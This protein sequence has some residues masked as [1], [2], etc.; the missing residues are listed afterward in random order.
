V[1]KSVAVFALAVVVAVLAIGSMRDDSATAD[2][3]AHIAAGLLKVREGRIDLYATQTP[4]IESLIAMPLAIAGE[5]VPDQ[6]RSMGNRPWVFGHLLL[7][8]G[9]SDAQR[10][11]RMARLP[12]IALFLALCFA[13]WGFV[14]EVTGNDAAALAAFAM[15]GFCPTLLAHGRLAT[16][17]MGVTFFAFLATALFLRLL[18]APSKG[19]AIATGVAVACTLASKISGAL[20]LPFFAIVL[21]LWFAERRRPAPADAGGVPRRRLFWLEWRGG[22]ETLPASAGG[23][24]GVPLAAITCIATFI[25]IYLVLGRSFDLMLPFRAYLSELRAVRAFYV[26]NPLPQFLL[27]EFSQKGW[28]QYYLVAMAVKTPLPAL[29]LLV[30]GVL[31]TRRF[32]GI[33]CIVFAALFLL[34]S[35]F[36]SLNLGIRHVLP[37]YPFLY[38]A[39]A[40]AL[41]DASRRMRIAAGVLV[42]AHVLVALLAYPSYLSYFNALIGSPRNADRILIDSNLDWGQDLRRLGLWARA[43]DVDVVRVHYFGAG[44]VELELG[45]RGARWPAPRPQLLPKG[46]FAVSRHFYRLSFLPSRSPIDYDTYLRASHA[47]YVTTI[48]GSIDVYRVD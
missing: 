17:D 16:V 20:L 4:L 34:V 33:V 15:T 14:R 7:Y 46:W 28:P 21:V 38:A 40:I 24:A 43:N 30:I 3:A 44:N 37:I 36:S 6:W 1:G 32:E 9:G 42:A 13:V 47:R 48:G 5:R 26:A 23:D 35:A 11:L 29:T 18:R 8:R 31:H 10:I 39:A 45:A 12:V 27:G 22:S 19:V 41:F 25:L 2:E